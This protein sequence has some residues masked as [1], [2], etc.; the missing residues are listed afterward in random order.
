MLSFSRTTKRSAAWF[1]IVLLFAEIF[2]PYQSFALTGGPS[3]PEVESF[4]PASVNE[5]VDPATGT[6]SYNIPLFDV[7]GYPVNLS[8]QSEIGM[9]QEASVVGLG[10]NLNPGVIS[11]NLRGLPDDFDGDE[12]EKEFNMKPNITWGVT[13]GFQT[14]L[15]GYKSPGV[16][17][18][19]PFSIGVHIG[20]NHNNYNGFG[21]EYGI[22]PSLSLGEKNKMRFNAGL[23]LT[24]SSS[25]G[26]GFNPSL[27]FSKKVGTVDDY[28]RNA[29]LSIGTAINS[30]Q[31]FKSISFAPF[32]SISH[33]AVKRKKGEEGAAWSHETNSRS[34]QFNFSTPT[35]V[36]SIQFPMRNS[37]FTFSGR[38]GLELFGVQ[39]GT[40]LSG[41]FTK[42]EL[43]TNSLQSK[44]Y[45]M[46]YAHHAK[47]NLN[48]LLDFNRE[49]DNSFSSDTR[50]LPLSAMT[51]DI[52][53][54]SGQGLSGS[55]QLRRSDVPTTFDNRSVNLN[56]GKSLGIEAGA[57]NMVRAGADVDFNVS[58]SYANKWHNTGSNGALTGLDFSSGPS[59]SNP[60]QEPA[61]F[62]MA[63]ERTVDDSG[64]FNALGGFEPVRPQLADAGGL[65][66]RTNNTLVRYNEGDVIQSLP[67]TPV[68]RS[69]R[70][71]R[72][73]VISYLTA[74]EAIKYGLDKCI[75]N[76]PENDFKLTNPTAVS[77]TEVPRKEHHLSEITVL[78][79]DGQ[80]YIY[81][82][83]AYNT[84]Q[85][86]VSFS[87]DGSGSN[88]QSGLAGYS[89]ADASIGNTKG[90][91]NY[92]NR[93]RTPAYAHSYLLTA[94]VSSDYVDRTGNGCTPDDYGNYTIFNYTRIASYLPW[95]TPYKSGQ[96]NFNQ[97]FR[98]DPLD[99]K[100]S[101]I[102]GEKEVWLLHSIVSRTHV[103]C[104]YYDSQ[105]RTD[106]RSSEGSPVRA[107]KLDKIVLYTLSDWLSN[108]DLAEPIKTV[109]FEYSQEL[110]P[111]V[112]NTFAQD[113]GKLTL[114]KVWIEFGRSKKGQETPYEFMYSTIN[115]PYDY[116]NIDRWGVYKP[117]PQGVSCKNHVS[118]LSNDEFP[119]ASQNAV[120]ANKYA[121]AW[122]LTR[123]KLPSG[124]SITV[125]YEAGDYAYVQNRRAMRMFKIYDVRNKPDLNVP[126]PGAYSDLFDKTTTNLYLYFELEKPLTQNH[127]SLLV[128]DYLQNF[129]FGEYL[130]YKCLVNLAQ[131][132]APARW[133]YVPGYAKIS[134]TDFGL[135]KKAGSTNYDLAYIKLEAVGLGDREKGKEANPIAKTAWQFA[136]LNL[137]E[138]VYGTPTIDQGDAEQ[139]LTAIWGLEEQF[140]QFIKGFNN[141]MR[142]ESFG[143]R[144]YLP[145]SWIRLND[146]DYSKI[147]GG[148]RVKRIEIDD[149]WQDM[150][151]APHETQNYGQEYFYTTVEN[152]DTISS[153]VAAYEPIIGGDENP[154]RQPVFSDE[155]V[156]CAPD[157]EHYIEEPL[158]E[159]FFPAPTIIYSKV[160]VRNL[161]RPNVSRSATGW[162][163]HEFYT[164]R[165]FPVLTR[166]TFL[167]KKPKKSTPLLGLL[168][169]KSIDYMT[170]VEG[171]VVELNDMHG[172]PKATWVYDEFGTRLSGMEY[173]Y[174]QQPNGQLDN[175]CTV[176]YPD[177]KVG[178][179]VQIGV[180]ISVTADARES[181]SITQSG[182]VNL[183]ID[184][185]MLPP[186]LPIIAPTPYPS[187]Q[188]EETR[189]RSFTLTKVI[190]RY[191]QLDETIAYD[192]GA[193]VSTK[194]VAYDS[195]TGDVLLTQTTNSFSDP[196]YQFTYPA[197]WAYA[198]M[199]GA[200]RNIG[201]VFSGLNCAN[202]KCNIAS[203]GEKLFFPGDEISVLAGGA[204]KDRL[205][206]KDIAADAIYLIDAAGNPANFNDATLKII[207][208]GHRNQAGLSIGAFTSLN[209]PIQNGVL[210]FDDLHVLDASAQEMSDR[211]QTFCK[212]T[213][214]CENRQQ[215]IDCFLALLNAISA[216]GL[217]FSSSYNFVPLWPYFTQTG[218]EFIRINCGE[219]TIN[220]SPIPIPGIKEY[221][222]Q[223]EP[224]INALDTYW[225]VSNSCRAC[226]VR[227][228][229][230]N[231]WTP[232]TVRNIQ[233][234]QIIPNIGRCAYNQEFEI[235]LTAQ[236]IL[237]KNGGTLTGVSHGQSECLEFG[238]CFDYNLTKKFCGK[239]VGGQ[240]N[241]Y[242]EGILG[243]WRPK[244][245]HVYLS[246]REQKGVPT[247]LYNT[248]TRLQVDGWIKDF[249]S[250]WKKP[251][252]SGNT[253]WVANPNG[254][255]WAQET[256]RINPLG[257]AV[258]ARDA[259][260]RYTAESLGYW[261]SFVNASAANA[262]YEE[263]MY[264]GFED[265]SYWGA[266]YGHL[267]QNSCSG[268]DGEE[269]A[270]RP[271]PHF[272]LDYQD[273]SSVAHTGK[274]SLPLN[275]GEEPI[276]KYIRIKNCQLYKQGAFMP[277][278]LQECDCVGNFSPSPGKK[279]VFSAWVREDRPP[280]ALAFTDPKVEIWAGAN[281]YTFQT[282]GDIIEGWQRIYGEFD[283]PPDVDRLA[284]NLYPG[285]A[286]T[287]YDDLR[288]HPF[289]A[290]FK[291]YGYDPKTLRF[292]YELD[293]NN[294][295]TK[296]EYESRSGRLE[297]VKKETERGVMTIQETRF[298]NAKE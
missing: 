264:E 288:I 218:C 74:T 160:T 151:G 281:K 298:S 136:R 297:R 119:Y 6:F 287:F 216:D 99:D 137:P 273:N 190:T 224:D 19:T 223:F 114:K 247:L 186:L 72:K 214:Y 62:K 36:P 266:F 67:D 205:W 217:L 9:E 79:E 52:F 277:Y 133:E 58:Y 201:A 70:E 195:E 174:K 88:C 286:L 61:Y 148:S 213:C 211:W 237:P 110:C 138:I 164:A 296:Y 255:T 128:R 84:I 131:P 242:F 181:G 202:G 134:N 152:G 55:Y 249:S 196:I 197:H 260:S 262:R 45:G 159:M 162:T 13:G 8:Y 259:L 239:V 200:Y 230:P 16:K 289:D 184:N 212:E 199:A 175:R 87:V 221:W 209:N 76:Y 73:Q 256:T 155:T 182:G 105:S 154:W 102:Q 282:S 54:V 108:P 31:G 250:F 40:Q 280:T 124:G 120:D 163:V 204:F 126:V 294:Y 167:T 30:R 170:A 231:G 254:W 240:V 274:S 20:L 279:Y 292:M 90:K 12:V 107:R 94:V 26:I 47:Y 169:I 183:N 38:L 176:I 141:V 243:N 258:E 95:R 233:F 173:R 10:W 271:E 24:A 144:I 50:H 81:G 234:S 171:F 275:P 51:A 267:F 21:I 185:F 33:D 168:K 23:G 100:A 4:T 248:R 118:P 252:G 215:E 122:R 268:T 29:G 109:R 3:Q 189:F 146:P 111:G 284:M 278:T 193:R 66:V 75:L 28:D 63:G 178:N 261:N 285:T 236:S 290:S 18:G 7:G 117:N 177:G 15:F 121:S 179:S 44:A 106:N 39:G 265:A 241:P 192:L 172:K 235:T 71:K 89:A 222:A 227:I 2:A 48:A 32:M 257:I 60:S 80:R 130:Y 46:L 82:I 127:P 269:N 25:D 191:G 53:S 14:E 232:E 86:E 57:G 123:I 59:N 112:P 161:P 220:P 207:R 42:Q 238:R 253:R 272:W 270:C 103:A 97:G 125:Q 27:S 5:L 1:F 91:E 69:K 229:L 219:L 34:V 92:Y 65:E 104:F 113:S 276:R 291:A 244:R 93:V 64:Y 142:D 246:D 198:G 166:N 132:S 85:D 203:I 143:R 96:A 35:Y 56:A 150:A 101:F 41:Y 188:Y 226:I 116:K 83:P 206:V 283:I 43:T 129:I 139:I 180:D 49:K 17:K 295:F 153:G 145:K 194:N 210:N 11:R 22:T 251:N 78:R 37:S 165:D 156:L 135:A 77:R 68:K 245:A 149:A 263:I 228:Y 157:N 147:G 187:S 158:G 208:S 115:P 140:K 293:D 225:V 98:S